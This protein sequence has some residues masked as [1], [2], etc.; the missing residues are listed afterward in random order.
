MRDDF[1]TFIISH[2]RPDN[3]ITYKTLLGAG[4]TGKVYIVID[5]EDKTAAR[6]REK[7]PGIVLMFSKEAIAKTFDEGD[8]SGNRRTTSYVRNACWGLAEQV[9][10]RYFLVLDD[11]YTGF[12]YRGA[13]DLSHK[14]TGMQSTADQCFLAMLDFLDVSLSI[15]AIAFSQGGDWIGGAGNGNEG[16]WR[17]GATLR[18]KAM[19]S[20]FCSTD[21]PFQFV[22]RLNEDV[23]T[24]VSLSIRGHL[25]FTVMQ[26]K[27]IQ[28]QTQATPGGMTEAYLDAGTYVKSFYT[29]MY[30]P[31]CVKVGTMGDHRCGD[32]RIHHSINWNRAA[33]CILREA[34]RKPRP[35]V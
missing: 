4:Y 14:Y 35:N 29:V 33:P 32:Y 15:T 24:Y 5:D 12:E 31:S 8:N 20:F 3:V 25:F 13:A 30:A 26:A 1:C 7:F 2:G 17:G 6:Y 19:N 23:N 11:D 18:R 22:G 10:C 16:G 34:H 27:I 9:G 21:R 28:K